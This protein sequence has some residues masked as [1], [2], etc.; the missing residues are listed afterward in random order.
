MHY[1]FNMLLSF[2][3]LS[4]KK[5]TFGVMGTNRKILYSG[6]TVYHISERKPVADLQEC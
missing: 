3:I 4:H 6:M 2:Y 5:H 1:D